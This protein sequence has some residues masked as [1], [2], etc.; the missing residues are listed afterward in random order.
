[1][2]SPNLVALIN[3]SRKIAGLADYGYRS[4][5]GFAGPTGVIAHVEIAPLNGSISRMGRS[6]AHE[7]H[8]YD[9]LFARRPPQLLIGG[10]TKYGSS[11]GGDEQLVRRRP[12]D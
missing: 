5:E 4:P 3:V 2:T 12:I 11:P 7:D 9:D 10:D 8:G 6:H 1:M